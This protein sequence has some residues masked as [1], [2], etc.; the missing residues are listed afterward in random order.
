MNTEW[1]TLGCSQVPLCAQE[2]LNSDHHALPVVPHCFG[3]AVQLLS[4]CQSQAPASV[5]TY[6]MVVSATCT[7][8]QG[9]GVLLLQ[10]CAASGAATSDLAAS[11]CEVLSLMSRHTKVRERETPGVVLMGHGLNCLTDVFQ[12][13]AETVCCRFVTNRLT[14]TLLCASSQCL[15]SMQRIHNLLSAVLLRSFRQLIRSCTSN[16]GLSKP[17]VTWYDCWICCTGAG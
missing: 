4:R 17:G 11:L 15:A 6:L 14:S 2:G 7:V 8:C 12:K 3:S 1:Y 13:C 9:A 5:L 10:A 16:E